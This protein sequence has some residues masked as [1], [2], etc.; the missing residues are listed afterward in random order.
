V[1]RVHPF[2]RSVQKM[3]AVLG[4]APPAQGKGIAGNQM[5]T[6]LAGRGKP[7]SNVILTIQLRQQAGERTG[8]NHF[9]MWQSI[10]KHMLATSNGV[11]AMAAC[12][13]A[14]ADKAAQL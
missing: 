10:L 6:A 1:S 7:L 13:A 9:G 14:V 11:R 12:R 8:R 4:Y 2:V 5:S 3:H